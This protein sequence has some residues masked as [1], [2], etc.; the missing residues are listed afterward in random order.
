MVIYAGRIA[1]KVFACEPGKVADM[2][3]PAILDCP[4]AGGSTDCCSATSILLTRSRTATPLQS[5]CKAFSKRLQE[6]LWSRQRCFTCLGICFLNPVISCS[7][8]EDEE[9][10]LT[11]E[12]VESYCWPVGGGVLT[13]SCSAYEV[14]SQPLINARRCIDELV[15]FQHFGK[16]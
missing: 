16:L 7:A 8:Q 12:T 5:L 1:A 11:A 6:A 14:G 9:V 13:V 2:H 3:T 4:F 10:V 15:T